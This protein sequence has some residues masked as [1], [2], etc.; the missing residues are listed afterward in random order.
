MIKKMGDGN[1]R[2][3]NN[4]FRDQI[5]ID[6]GKV[7]SGKATILLMDVAGKEIFRS[8]SDLSNQSRLKVYL[9]GRN[10]SAGIYMLKV[11]TLNGQFTA[12]IIKQ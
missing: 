10:I 3:I 2:V 8:A 9:G 4:P 12:R 5:E 7:Q 6:F 1:F 11:K